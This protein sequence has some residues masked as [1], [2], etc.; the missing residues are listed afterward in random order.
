MLV[1]VE[2]TVA[3]SAF[4]GTTLKSNN[5]GVVGSSLGTI[6]AGVA[7]GEEA[8]E[9]GVEVGV[10]V[11]VEALE[12]GLQR[13]FRLYSFSRK[14]AMTFHSLLW[15]RLAITMSLAV[16]GLIPWRPGRRSIVNCEPTRSIPAKHQTNDLYV[17][18]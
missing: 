17:C 10:D 18:M 8:G 15:L 13:Y 16:S 5:V 12:P 11:G 14:G 6:D 9:E 2:R 7:D 3:I 1:I 4:A